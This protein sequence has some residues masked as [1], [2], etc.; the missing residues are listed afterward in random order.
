MSWE[1][2]FVLG[3]V[4][5][6]TDP[7]AATAISRRLGVPRRI[8]VI[9]EGE[10]LINDATALVALRTAVVAGVSGTFSLW[11]AGLEFLGFGDLQKPSWGVALYWATQN[12]S[13]LQGEWWAFLFPGLWIGFTVLSLTLILAGIDEVS[14]PRLRGLKRSKRWWRR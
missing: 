11:H 5:S 2:A 9:V 8:V 6:P 12:S 4:V 3:A 1:A 7:I 14:N 10:S 13:V